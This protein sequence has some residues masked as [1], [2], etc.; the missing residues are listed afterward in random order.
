MS[1][2]IQNLGFFI[3]II[4]LLGLNTIKCAKTDDVVPINTNPVDST[5]NG[6]GID[7]SGNT[8][9]VTDSF[10]GFILNEVLYDPPGAL[11]GDANGDGVRDPNDD[12]FLEFVNDS[13]SSYNLSGYMIFDADRLALGTPNHVFPE[14]TIIN[15]SQA[16]VV[17][18]G[19]NPSGLF[20]GA[21][22]FVA[23]NQVLNLNNSGDF[24]TFT[25]S[26]GNVIIEFDITP[27]SDNPNESYT[28]SPDITGDFMQHNSVISGTLFSPG[29]NADGSSF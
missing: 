1:R 28:R 3:L 20:G 16:V 14:N 12:E 21:Q 22:V 2:R 26:L 13:D 8:G 27:L 7:S 5:G 17:F 9:G 10:A 23:S 6:G 19:G 25:D 15:P 4:S 29:T 11:A 24:M 18:G